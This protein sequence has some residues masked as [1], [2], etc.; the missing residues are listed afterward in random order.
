MWRLLGENFPSARFRRQV[1]LRQYIADFATHSAR[2]VIEIDGG[3]HDEPGDALRTKLIEREGYRVLRFW[4]NDVLGNP[5]GV[6]T[7][8][9]AALREQHPHLASPIKGEEWGGCIPTRAG[10]ASPSPNPPLSR[11]RAF[12]GAGRAGERTGAGRASA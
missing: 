9:D 3:Q 5:D 12:A 6:L 10:R 7:V 8:V 1:P 2:L 4:N 11:E